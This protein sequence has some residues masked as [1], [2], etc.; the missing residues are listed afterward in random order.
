MSENLRG[1]NVLEELFKQGKKK[2]FLTAREITDALEELSFDADQINRIFDRIAAM[3]IKIVDNFDA[4]FDIDNIL[5]YADRDYDSS[6]TDLVTA[7]DSVKQY[8]KEIGR[9]PLLSTEEEIDLAARMAA[10]DET[11]KTRLQ[12][13]NLRL[14]VSIAK[15]Y[16][17][18][19]MQFLDL[20][21]EG[22]V[23]LLKAVEK[24]D[25]TKGFKFSTAAASSSSASTAPRCPDMLLLSGGSLASRR[26]Y[27]RA[28]GIFPAQAVGAVRPRRIGKLVAGGIL[29]FQ[30]A[31]QI[32]A[33]QN[34]QGFRQRAVIHAVQLYG[35]VDSRQIAAQPGILHP[36]I[37][38]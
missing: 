31:A 13:A 33:V 32:L 25:Y 26:A 34:A 3:D 8:L 23:G 1:A 9:I 38:A 7:D 17:R 22:N 35:L 4:D 14:V 21:Q 18:R 29:K 11:A 27:R 24:F 15:K 37:S 19:G 6:E 28:L 30:P 20:I 16:V 36:V 10:G 2:G 5:D 12:E